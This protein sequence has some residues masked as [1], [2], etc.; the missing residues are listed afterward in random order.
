M[1]SYPGKMESKIHFEVD[2]TVPPVVMP[3]R[4]VP[5]AIKQKLKVELN[6][7]EEQGVIKN[8]IEPIG[9]V[10]SLVIT[11]KANGN[12]R[13]CIDTQ[14]LNK[15]LK[16]SHYPLAVIEDVLPKLSNAGV[17]SKADLKD[18][19]LQIELD[20]ESST[21]TTFQTP[22]NRWQYAECRLK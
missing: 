21:L 18:R 8:V 12:I 13:V 19:F 2:E 9:W 10:S 1:F 5:V 20:D 6:K 17:F 3:P 7:L 16:R 11:Q 15:A 4:R 22:W 14:Q